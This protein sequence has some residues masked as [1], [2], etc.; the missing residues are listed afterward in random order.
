MA[1]AKSVNMLIIAGTKTVWLI[2]SFSTASQNVRG[3]K[4]GTATC[5]APK[6]GAANIAGKSA[7]GNIDAACR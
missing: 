7:P 5:K 1:S 3:L 2:R 4:R 6:A